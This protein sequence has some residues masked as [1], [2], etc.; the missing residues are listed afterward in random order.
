MPGGPLSGCFRGHCFE[1]ASFRDDFVME[2]NVVHPC[3]HFFLAVTCSRAVFVAVG[4]L[5]SCFS[6]IARDR[7]V[8]PPIRYHS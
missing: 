2:G 1:H 8:L 3:R 6:C 5:R 4:S 7:I